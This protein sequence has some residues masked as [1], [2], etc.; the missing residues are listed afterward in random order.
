MR[1]VNNVHQFHDCKNP[2]SGYQA[3]IS[4]KSVF[5]SKLNIGRLVS[6]SA[7][8]VLIASCGGGSASDKNTPSG[9]GSS[10][11]QTLNGINAGTAVLIKSTLVNEK[12]VLQ[13]AQLVQMYEKAAST[14]PKD[15]P[16]ALQV[17]SNLGCAAA[18]R[19]AP[20]LQKLPNA[21]IYNSVTE[22]ATVKT[23]MTKI[24]LLAGSYSSDEVPQCATN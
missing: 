3:R 24:A 4:M 7:M 14:T 22:I 10:S 23:A 5:K 17:L 1:N 6:V 21:Q 18:L 19:T 12:D 8:S 11:T 20:S 2:T 15:R 16:T 13:A 9:T